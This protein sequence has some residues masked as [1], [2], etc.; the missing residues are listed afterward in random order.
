MERTVAEF[1]RSGAPLAER[2]AVA[3]AL[4]RAVA[5]SHARG[6]VHGALSPAAVLVVDR[7]EVVLVPAAPGSGHLARAGFDAPEVARGGQPSRRSDAF[8]LGALTWLVLAGRGPFEADD[9]LEAIRRAMFEDPGP[10]RR[11]APGIPPEVD[12]AL[13]DLLEKRESRRGRPEGLVLALDAAAGVDTATAPPPIPAASAPLPIRAAVA[14]HARPDARAAEGG[15]PLEPVR[16]AELRARAARVAPALRSGAAWANGALRAVAAWAALALRSGAARADG[17]LRSAAAACS[18]AGSAL[19]RA[20]R[21]ARGQLPVSPRLAPAP[22]LRRAG[23][24]ALVVL[25][26]LALGLLLVLLLPGREDTL[27]RDVAALVEQR[28]L[29]G[30]RRLLDAAAKERPGDPV[31]EK[32][33]GDVACAR[34]APGEC[35]RRYR[36]ALA[37]RP[38]LRTDPTLRANARRLLE[39]AQPCKTRRAAA[40]LIG[41]IRDPE[42]LPALEEARRSGG[43]LGFLCTGDTIDRAITA[44]RAEVGR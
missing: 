42:A 13:G 8:S 31:V 4:A 6:R 9:P 26:V 17:A 37:A 14:G 24:L 40:Q 19:V 1:A 11:H 22:A 7:G 20:G 29:A 39:R 5:D 43:I 12:A 25:P 35:V 27:E 2:L 3:R 41:E 32:L 33:R 18:A 10:V 28:D 44:T 36:V 15:A 38:Q 16:R 30:A 34:G 21:A 23:L